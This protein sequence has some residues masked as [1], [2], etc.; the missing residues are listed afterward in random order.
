MNLRD[1][2]RIKYGYDTDKL[3]EEL[4][5]EEYNYC[6]HIKYLNYIHNK[7]DAASFFEIKIDT[8]IGDSES[9]VINFLKE[10]A[11]ELG[12]DIKEINTHQ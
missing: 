2:M 10:V 7:D 3:V 6:K 12:V 1:K 5:K 11:E 8:I 4:N 9:G